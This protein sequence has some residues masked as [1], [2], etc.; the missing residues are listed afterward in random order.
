[1]RRQCNGAKQYTEAAAMY[2]YVRWVGERSIGIEAGLEGS[3]GAY[4]SENA[5]MSNA[6]TGE[7]PVRRK[8]KDSRVK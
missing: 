5:G 8:P 4:G 2:I 1:M 6:K 3:R 7:I